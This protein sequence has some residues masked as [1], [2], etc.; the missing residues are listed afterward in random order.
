M[1][2]TDEILIFICDLLILSLVNQWGNCGKLSKTKDI[3]D[4]L[5]YRRDELAEKVQDEGVK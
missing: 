1:K 4:S 5:K 2:N 3:I